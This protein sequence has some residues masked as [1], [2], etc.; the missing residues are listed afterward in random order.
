[1]LDKQKILSKVT[2]VSPGNSKEARLR[3]SGYKNFLRWQV[4][5]V[6]L[7]GKE[8]MRM[9]LHIPMNRQAFYVLVNEL[10]NLNDKEAGYSFTIEVYSPLWDNKTNQMTG[11]KA[12]SGT[13][14]VGRRQTD[15]GIINYILLT[16]A[17]REKKYAFKLSPTPFIKLYKNGKAMSDEDSSKVWTKAYVDTL[18]AVLDLFP[19]ILDDEDTPL[20]DGGNTYTKAASKNKS[21]KETKKDD[22][23]LDSFDDII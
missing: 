16:D 23:D 5:I 12:L 13:V 9:A 11:E 3:L 20:G 6:D 14:T 2:L 19:E 22:V 10:E 7:T 15:D 1:M 8:K 21:N 4:F 17:A 18:K